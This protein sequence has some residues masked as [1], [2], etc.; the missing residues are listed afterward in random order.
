MGRAKENIPPEVWNH[1][2]NPIGI[3]MILAIVFSC[4][5]PEGC[6]IVGKIFGALSFLWIVIGFITLLATGYDLSFPTPLNA[7]L[8]N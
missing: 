3:L 6:M 1:Y 5:L 4:I 8:T 2:L 7:T